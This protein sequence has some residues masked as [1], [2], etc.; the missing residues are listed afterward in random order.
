MPQTHLDLQRASHA[1][2]TVQTIIKDRKTD[3][4]EE[5]RHIKKLP[6]HIISAGLGQ[7]LVFLKA[8]GYAGAVRARLDDWMATRIPPGNGN[9]ELLQRIIHGDADF[10]RRATAEVLEYL[11]WLKRFAEAEIASDD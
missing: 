6:S 5:K 4:K 3:P 10:M 1:W 2:D 8:K 11:T 9:R 7:A